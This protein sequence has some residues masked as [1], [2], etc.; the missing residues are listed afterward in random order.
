MWFCPLEQAARPA[1]MSAASEAM[2]REHVR[3]RGIGDG[4]GTRPLGFRSH[5]KRMIS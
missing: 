1:P 4:M 5:F 2:T 3:R